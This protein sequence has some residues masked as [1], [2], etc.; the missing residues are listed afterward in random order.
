M[1]DNAFRYGN[2]PT[3]KE[4]PAGT[5]AIFSFN[6]DPTT[7]ETQWGTKFSFPI[8]LIKHDSYPLLEDGPMN[9]AWESKSV[10]AKMLYEDIINESY[11]H[12]KDLMKYYKKNNW[13]LTRFDNGAYY[14]SVL[15]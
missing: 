4:V 13:Q 1:D 10:C 5:E 15:K 14:I 9:M 11:E 8:S 3:M 6:G 2:K 7:T 12:H